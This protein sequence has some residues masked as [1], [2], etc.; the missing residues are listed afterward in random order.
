MRKIFAAILLISLCFMT[1]CSIFRPVTPPTVGETETAPPASTETGVTSDTTSDVTTDIHPTADPTTDPTLTPDIPDDP[2]VISFLGVGDNIIY[3][4]N[5]R[6]A[7]SLAEPGGRQYNFKPAYKNVA[8]LISGA[9]V[10]FIN[11][12]V[13]MSGGE[14]SYYPRFNSPQDLGHD[15]VEIGFDVINIATN[16]MLDGNDAGLRSTIEFWKSFDGITMIGGYEN[17]ADY[18]AIRYYEKDGIVIA[19]LAYTEH[20]NFI[21]PEPNADTVIPYFD[22]ST[23][24]RQVAY[25]NQTADLVIVSAHWGDEYTYT[26]SDFQTHYAQVIADAGADVIIGHHPHVIQ[27]IEWLTGET[28]GN[29]TLCAYSLGNFLSEMEYDYNMLGGILTFDISKLADDTHV[30]NVKFLPCVTYFDTA[31]YNNSVW[32]LEDFTQDMA[33][34]HGIITYDWSYGYKDSH[35][36]IL[37]EFYYIVRQNISEDFLPDYFK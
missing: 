30:E 29:K 31:F 7:A 9:D 35:H 10:S 36:I 26:P 18:D 27:K 11:Q 22:E 25:A 1:S 12:E 17:A 3:Y 34:T 20:T 28:H 16:H 14:L 4:G 5:V 23:I 6:D 19:F 21:T 33:D 37:D 13:L 15:L 32:L 24:K 2:T 8:D